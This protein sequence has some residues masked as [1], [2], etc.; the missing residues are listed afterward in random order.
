MLGIRSAGHTG[1]LDPFATGLLVVLVGT[2]HPTRALRRGSVP[3]RTSP[4]RASVCGRTPTIGRARRSD[5]RSRTSGLSEAA[6]RAALAEFEGVQ[7]QRPPSF[8]AKHVEGVRSYRLARR[9][10][11]VELPEVT[12]TVHRIEPLGFDRRKGH[13]SGHGERRHVPPGHRARS[14]RAARRRRPPGGARR[15][16]IG[17]IRGGRGCAPGATCH[18]RISAGARGPRAPAGRRSGRGGP[19]RSAARAAGRG[20]CG[21][22]GSGAEVALL[23]DGELVAIAREAEGLLKPA[24][25]LGQP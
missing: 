12:V 1:T 22:R 18:R 2:G 8:S 9:G 14:R 25:V 23:W 10:R 11:S 5:R 4:P 16:A 3:R 21:R 7:R 17:T 19:A 24:V 20:A 15:E 13:L 6:V